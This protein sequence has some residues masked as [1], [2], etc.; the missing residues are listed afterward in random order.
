MSFHQRK[1][2]WDVHCDP[3]CSTLLCLQ[4]S[5]AAVAS[6][7]MLVQVLSGLINIKY[8]LLGC[9]GLFCS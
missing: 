4:M 2:F 6:L 9:N 1:V 8:V 3:S 5:S 7:P